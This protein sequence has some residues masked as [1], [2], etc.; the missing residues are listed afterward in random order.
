MRAKSPAD[1]RRR[2]GVRCRA[3]GLSVAGFLAFG[4]T[5]AAHAAAIFPSGLDGRSLS[6]WLLA[7][8]DLRPEQVVAVSRASI[9]AI[10]AGPEDRGG[11][12]MRV[13]VRSEAIDPAAQ[14]SDGVLS[15]Q[16]DVYVD[17]AGRKVR[18]GAA[19]GHEQRN[20]AGLGRIVARQE[21]AWSAPAPGTQLESVWR[22]VCDPNFTPPLR[23]A[24][25]PP[26]SPPSQ[27]R[28]KP[29]TDA[30]RPAPAQSLS[31]QIGAYPS[32]T[33]AAAARQQV[34]SDL[35]ARLPKARTLVLTAQVQGV[36]YYRLLVTGFGSAAEQR[37]YCD[38]LRALGRDCIIRQ[39]RPSGRSLS[40]SRVLQPGLAPS[41]PKP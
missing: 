31:V 33:Q 13:T 12:V 20:A 14:E 4:L 22:A 10:V 11:G 26:P 39:T 38:S 25:A 30:P 41:Q 40:A 3:A 19:T 18:Q 17:C 16:L 29:T 36:T 21:D 24:A 7:E 15:T 6:A 9:A 27:P 23:L 35:R 1:L 8:T 37:A 2:S 28:P 5:A 32:A 34:N